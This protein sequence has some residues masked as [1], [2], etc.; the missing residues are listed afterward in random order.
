MQNSL[1]NWAKK[2]FLPVLLTTAMIV[3][4]WEISQVFGQKNI[5]EYGHQYGY[6]T[7]R[8]NGK[9]ILYF[10]NGKIH[11]EGNINKDWRRE[12]TFTT[13]Y[14]NGNKESEVNY[15]DGTLEGIST[16]WYKNGYIEKKGKRHNN[17]KNGLRE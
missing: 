10:D 7:E 11:R 3:W 9:E 6:K 17:K 16:Q 1:S 4:T 15:I 13:Y 14:A 8:K 12:W 2:L 5:D